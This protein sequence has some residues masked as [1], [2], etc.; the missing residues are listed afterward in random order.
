MEKKLGVYICTGCSIGD[1]VDVEKLGNIS[2]NA[3]RVPVVKS[4]FALCGKEGIELIKNDIK[5]EE[6]NTVVVAAC[7]PRVRFTAV[8]SIASPTGVDV[9]W[10]LM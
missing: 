2:K 10:A 9:P 8:H 3:L 6:V 5:S 1:A 7:S 4:H